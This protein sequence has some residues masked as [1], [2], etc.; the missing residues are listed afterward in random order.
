[1]AKK[2]SPQPP[3]PEARAEVLR[4]IRE[5]AEPLMVRPLAKLLVAPNEIP[6]PQLT[7]ILDEYVASSELYLVPP[8]APSGKP[9]YWYQDHAALLRK[10]VLE[11]LESASGPLS[12]KELA[13]RITSLGKLAEQD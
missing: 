11:T 4:I 13:G 5:S 3:S 10:A 2:G 12:A 9:R 1:M 7:P 6:E 8:I